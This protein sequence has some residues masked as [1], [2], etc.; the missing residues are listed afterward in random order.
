MYLRIVVSLVLTLLV[1]A[2]ALGFGISPARKAHDYQP[3][4]S[5]D[6]SIVNSQKRSLDLYLVPRGEL[7]EYVTIS[8][9]SVVSPDDID[10]RVRYTVE[11]PPG[12]LDPGAHRIDIVALAFQ[13][14]ATE[15]VSAAA[16]VSSQVIIEV[17]YDG[18]FIETRL[19]YTRANQRV[20]FPLFNK[21]TAPTTVDIT[22]TI[23]GPTNEVLHAIRRTGND[24]D[25]QSFT[26]VTIDL[27]AL[28]PGSYL[29]RARVEHDSRMIPL[30]RLIE[31]GVPRLTIFD[32][33]LTL[34]GSIVR[35]D[36]PVQSQW[37]ERIREAYAIHDISTAGGTFI[38]RVRTPTIEIEAFGNAQFSTF[39]ESP[40]EGDYTISTV[41]SY[42]GETQTAERTFTVTPTG[43][44][45]MR[46]GQVT[47]GGTSG[48]LIF[49]VIMLVIINIVLITLVL[50][51]R[52]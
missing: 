47:A 3:S 38:E 28:N 42:D 26:E 22:L 51:R 8:P 15:T 24:V 20:V 36:L 44:S 27:P 43:I 31:V 40:G 5:G 50:R 2:P 19:D 18:A 35:I 29:L 34:S 49:G 33:E 48:W 6:I 45:L 4:I 1:A 25:A 52:R 7:A 10:R 17:P 39:W 12:T 37:N 21:G 9:S 30:E 32:Y 16:G 41:I 11:I 14:S 46:T 13:A 23:L